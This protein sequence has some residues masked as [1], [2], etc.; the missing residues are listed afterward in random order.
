MFLQP[1]DGVEQICRVMEQQ[2]VSMQAIPMGQ[3]VTVYVAGGEVAA[4]IVQADAA[5]TAGANMPF[6][7]LQQCRGLVRSLG[8]AFAECQLVVTREGSAY[9][10][11][12]SGA[13]NFWRCPHEVQQQIVHILAGYLS[14]PRSLPLHDSFD[15]ADGGSGVGQPLC[16]IGFP[17]R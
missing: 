4:T 6:L 8:L 2:A 16:E 12:V 3:R 13:P 7:P 17:E 10:L 15:W 9:C 1:H 5:Q 14:E 11:D